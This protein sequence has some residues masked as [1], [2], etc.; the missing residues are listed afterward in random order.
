MS[1]RTG[2]PRR[3]EAAARARGCTA[4]RLRT[5]RRSSTP[6]LTPRTRLSADN[7]P[8]S[9]FLTTGELERQKGAGVY[10]IRQGKAGKEVSDQKPEEDISYATLPARAMEGLQVMLNQLYLPLIETES[11]AWKA[12]VGVDD[13]TQEFF[14]AYHKFGETLG[15]AVA[16][17]Q[18]GFT[19]RRPETLFDIENK[20][21]AFNRAGNEPHIVKAFED[22]AEEWC[23]ATEQLLGESDAA[24][25]ESDDS[26]PESELEYW[27]TRM[28]K[29]N[30]ITE[31]LRGRE[32]KV[33]LGVLGA[34]KSRVLKR[35][36]L[37]DNGI[38]DANN[39]AKD[40]VKYLSTLEK[41]IEPLSTGT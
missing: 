3:P 22:V 32:C 34:A 11:K 35:W 25:T 26:G 6:P 37:L 36:K 20:A 7:A 19:L 38:T 23:T 41:Y 40:N 14:S 4:T 24:R 12:G 17:L 2:G 31:Q 30:S 16:S 29:F 10:F 27:R 21:A 9:L 39:E 1:E 18:G 28:A 5:S 13:S 33:V 8:P 15:E